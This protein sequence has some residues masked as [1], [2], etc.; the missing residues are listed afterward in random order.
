MQYVFISYKNEDLDFAENIVNRL[1]RAGFTAW[2]DARI[3][4]GE[5]LQTTIDQAIRDADALLG[6]NKP[7]DV[8]DLIARLAAIAV[9]TY[10][11]EP[12]EA[13]TDDD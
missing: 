6:R 13:G 7:I 2:T 9:Y 1:A 10:G 12:S 3:S 8:R 5:E 4:A 11:D